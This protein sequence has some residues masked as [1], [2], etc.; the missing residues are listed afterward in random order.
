MIIIE[1]L[2]PVIFRVIKNRSLIYIGQNQFFF[3]VSALNLVLLVAFSIDF[4]RNPIALSDS[5]MVRTYQFILVLSFMGSY[6]KL[7]FTLV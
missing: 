5:L 4:V 1:A 7:R 2:T 3:D 6:Q